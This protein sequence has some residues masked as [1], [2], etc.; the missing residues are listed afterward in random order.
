MGLRRKAREIALQFL[1]EHDFQGHAQAAEQVDS[2]L[3]R[4]V[5]WSLE[6]LVTQGI[7]GCCNEP[8]ILIPELQA[9]VQR[10]Q[11]HA[12]IDKQV[13]D[14]P[15]YGELRRFCLAVSDYYSLHD[16]DAATRL[17]RQMKNELRSFCHQALVLLGSPALDR[18]GFDAAQLVDGLD[19]FHGCLQSLTQL[20]AYV[21]FLGQGVCRQFE[22]L[23]RQI[24]THSHN[25]RLER[26]SIVDRNIL[27][28]ALLEMS[29]SDDV[30][31][32]VA[33]NEAL[34]IAKQYSNPDSV[35]FINGILDAAAAE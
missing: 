5:A 34:E 32:R 9:L 25:W 22:D 7:F 11:A 19:H 8:E 18:C 31:T 13:D 20:F 16:L 4:F 24:T 1:F 33:I 3:E 30:P 29:A 28:I 15:L 10:L 2:E 21:R 12:D 27:R 23:D 17:S 6:R 35:S 14:Q 26:M